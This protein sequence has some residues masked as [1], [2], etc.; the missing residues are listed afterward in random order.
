MSHGPLVVHETVPSNARQASTPSPAGRVDTASLGGG[1]AVRLGDRGSEPRMP[2]DAGRF[3]WPGLTRYAIRRVVSPSSR[4][5]IGW[6]AMIFM[7]TRKRA[8]SNRYL[9]SLAITASATSGPYA[10]RNGRFEVSA[11]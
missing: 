7:K 3:A 1:R 8:G 11:S 5:R 4:I 2:L 9:S 6:M 10:S